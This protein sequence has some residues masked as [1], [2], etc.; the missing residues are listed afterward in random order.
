MKLIELPRRFASRK[1]APHIVIASVAWRS[2]GFVGCAGMLVGLDC[3]A[4]AGLAKTAWVSSRGRRP[5]RSNGFC[6][7][8]P[9]C[10][11][12]GLPRRLRLLAKTLKV[13]CNDGSL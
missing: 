1:D 2:R 12:A 6:P 13:L 11:W 10:G 9:G 7:A 3:R 8:V 5:W 4:P